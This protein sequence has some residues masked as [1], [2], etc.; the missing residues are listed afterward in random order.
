MSSSTIEKSLQAINAYNP[1]AGIYLKVVGNGVKQHL[2]TV[3]V[4]WF[5]R[6]LM[7]LGCGNF[8]FKKTIAYVEANATLLF[9]AGKDSHKEAFKRL[10]KRIIRY[11]VR[12]GYKQIYLIN[13]I[14]KAWVTVFHPAKTSVLATETNVPV[15]ASPKKVEV[16]APPA[17]SPPVVKS[18]D[19]ANKDLLAR[20]S[21]STLAIKKEIPGAPHPVKSVDIADENLLLLHEMTQKELEQL[22]DG[23]FLTAHPFLAVFRIVGYVLQ[24]RSDI[25]KQLLDFLVAHRSFNKRIITGA[26]VPIQIA[27]KQRYLL[28][29]MHDP[30]QNHLIQ[31]N[32]K[33]FL[34]QVWSNIVQPQKNFL[35][36]NAFLSE[37]SANEKLEIARVL[38]E[39]FDAPSWEETA[40]L[41]HV[42][43]DVQ[44]ASKLAMAADTIYKLYALERISKNPGVRREF[45][46]EID[47]RSRINGPQPS[48]PT[49]IASTLQN[50][51]N[52]YFSPHHIP[53]TPVNQ[54]VNNLKIANANKIAQPVLGIMAGISAMF[55][56][57][58]TMSSQLGMTTVIPALPQQPTQQQLIALAVLCKAIELAKQQKA[59]TQNKQ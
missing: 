14:K 12:H 15:I 58:Q 53:T 24:Y 36:D 57:F 31:Q 7:W 49:L 37:L 13:Q 16:P 19:I 18:A 41:E 25:S 59:Q 27:L 10:T 29:L 34:L 45:T 20:L 43:R 40:I 30:A 51:L 4:N 47:R 44:N 21:T 5:G 8:C 33:S 50:N 2:V 39:D 9:Q 32:L 35:D 22:I 1:K 54:K 38:I 52:S 11:D 23:I 3:K 28:H 42:L 46:N 17:S 6:L 48:P 55:Y 56:A 26:S